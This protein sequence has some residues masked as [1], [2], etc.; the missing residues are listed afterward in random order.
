MRLFSRKA[1]W[2]FLLLL[3]PN[4]F[5]SDLSV[6][7]TLFQKTYLLVCL[8]VKWTF[9]VMFFRD[10]YFLA[11]LP[12][13]SNLCDLF[14]IVDAA[15]GRQQLEVL[16]AGPVMKFWGPGL[17]LCP[18][19]TNQHLSSVR[20]TWNKVCTFCPLETI[21]TEVLQGRFLQW[22]QTNILATLYSF[23]SRKQSNGT[24]CGSY[25]FM[26]LRGS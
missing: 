5:I 22:G 10:I 11:H 13:R 16:P 6:Q 7:C 24:W 12:W 14:L 1:V 25:R 3:Q 19:L 9:A 23:C 17:G 15:L 4:N 8:L 2:T 26:D 21:L 20:I 18:S